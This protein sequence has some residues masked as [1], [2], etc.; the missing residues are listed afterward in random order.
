MKPR[1]L[2][3]VGVLSYLVVLI[4]TLPAAMVVDSVQ[5]DNDRL[6]LAAV[7]GTLFKGRASQVRLQGIELGPVDWQIR[8]TRLLLGRLEYQLEFSGQRFPGHA[9]AG[10]SLSGRGYAQDVV[11]SL[12]Q[13]FLFNR[14]SPIELRTGGRLTMAIENVE[15]ED[16]FPSELAGFV[17][18]S[19]AQLIEPVQLA[20]GRVELVVSSDAG[21]IDGSV[22]NNG[23]TAVSGEISLTRDGQYALDFYI[24]PAADSSD[25]IT[26]V[27]GMAG[28]L[29]RDGRYRLSDS[30]TL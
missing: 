28:E 23:T 4:G 19:D 29:Q 26:E 8:A 10:I 30:G 27:L 7:E 24:T 3:I 17:Q 1:V 5:A 2:V 11:M 21:K 20:L 18:W 9:V 15:F 25:E 6:V 14:W 13:D 16:D 12:D 22:T